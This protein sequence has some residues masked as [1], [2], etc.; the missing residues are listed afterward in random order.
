MGAV[1]LVGKV[2]SEKLAYSVRTFSEATDIGISTIY[3]DARS[4]RLVTKVLGDGRRKKRIILREDG[5][6]YLQS[7]SDGTEARQNGEAA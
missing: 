7:L 5:L 2:T 1:S 4:G 6:D 3:E